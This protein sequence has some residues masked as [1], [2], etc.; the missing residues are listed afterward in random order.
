MIAAPSM[1]EPKQAGYPFDD[2]QRDRLAEYVALVGRRR[3]RFVHVASGEGRPPES[4]DLAIGSVLYRGSGGQ[5]RATPTF[6]LRKF[7]A[8]SAA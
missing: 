6:W 1:P 4:L 8:V 3:T 7:R 5:A 2:A